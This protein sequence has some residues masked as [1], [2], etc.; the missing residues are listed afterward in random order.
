ME[1]PACYRTSRCSPKTWNFDN[2]AGRD[3][4]CVAW[5][6]RDRRSCTLC[7]TK[8]LSALDRG[9]KLTM[10]RIQVLRCRS[11]RCPREPA[12]QSPR[13]KQLGRGF[14]SFFSKTIEHLPP[15]QKTI[16]KK[17]PWLVHA[18]RNPQIS[19]NLMIPWFLTS[20]HQKWWD[21]S[22]PPSI[23]QYIPIHIS[24]VYPN[25]SLIYPIISQYI[26]NIPHYIPIYQLEIP[27]IFGWRVFGTTEASRRRSWTRCGSDKTRNGDK[28]WPKWIGHGYHGKPWRLSLVI[29][30]EYHGI[31]WLYGI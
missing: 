26:P 9:W 21:F 16:K 25:I 30:W 20:F 19:S 14:L 11:W 24:L 15:S 29:S 6:R 8:F 4:G 2:A 31:W 13:W 27:S 3:W 23:S 12:A 18:L 5:Y 22:K 7:A 1:F 28:T 10:L 17:T